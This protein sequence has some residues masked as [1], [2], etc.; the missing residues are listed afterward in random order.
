[1]KLA[2]LRKLSIEDLTTFVSDKRTE[3]VEKRR[4][5]HAGELQNPKSIT[6]IRRDIAKGL[7][8]LAEQKQAAP[9]KEEA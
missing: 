9:K 3:L 8:I 4:S 6:L 7:T 2:E 1:M 5:L